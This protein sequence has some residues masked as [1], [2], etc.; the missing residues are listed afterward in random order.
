[1]NDGVVTT[2][3][4]LAKKADESWRQAY[5]DFLKDYY[6]YDK[7]NSFSSANYRMFLGYIDGDEVPELMIVEGTY[8]GAMVFVFTY[9]G[10]YV[11]QVGEYGGDGKFKYVER[12]NLIQSYWYGW[13]DSGID[14]FKIKNGIQETVS[15]FRANAPWGV[16]SEGKANKYT[17][18]G[19]TVTFAEYT[20]KQKEMLNH[21][22]VSRGYDDGVA[23]TEENVIKLLGTDWQKAYWNYLTD[24]VKKSGNSSDKF[25][26]EYIDEDDVPE[27]VID[28]YVGWNSFPVYCYYNGNVVELGKW[29]A[30]GTLVYAYKANLI[31]GYSMRKGIE[32]FAFSGILDGKTEY[33]HSFSNN[34]EA[35]PSKVEYTYN[36]Q[37][38]TKSE[39]EARL[40][41]VKSGKTWIT[42]DNSDFSAITNANIFAEL[43]K[44]ASPQTTK[45][46]SLQ[47]ADEVPATLVQDFSNADISSAVVE[48]SSLK[49][50]TVPAENLTAGKDYLF[51][52]VKDKNADNLLAT[53][54]IIYIDQKTAAA[55]S[56]LTFDYEKSNISGE[57]LMFEEFDPSAVSY[58]DLDNDGDVTLKDA[59]LVLKAALKIVSLEDAQKA[60]ADVDGDSD[61][62]LK[63][64]QLILKRALRII[65]TFPMEAV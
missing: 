52:V 57:E 48:A 12:E 26:F 11:N 8:H 37:P 64:A 54:N 17:Y 65:S 41:E 56:G 33:V 14:F 9:N 61:V 58:G 44:P 60:S 36:Q 6:D 43:T 4:K 18:N 23:V 10:E 13:E 50:V 39:Y 32:S 51:L 42:R 35:L 21:N 15:S 49:E 24:Y 53:D 2:T 16:A 25:S 5:I 28:G 38:V 62:T 30:Y 27:L 31:E 22:F 45:T 59:Q 46:A 20:A 1:M 34:A 19:S 47:E 29:G 63:D 55:D 40:E 7:T 3:I